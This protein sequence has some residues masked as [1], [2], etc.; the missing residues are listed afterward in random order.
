MAERETARRGATLELGKYAIS[1]LASKIRDALR[2]MY[3]I[4]RCVEG[5]VA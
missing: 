1:C 2:Q 5:K 3:D 4:Q